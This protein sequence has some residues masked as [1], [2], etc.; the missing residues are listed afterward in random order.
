VGG[1]VY[2]SGVRVERIR[3]SY[4]LAYLPAESEPVAFGVHDV[5][6]DHY[7][8]PAAERPSTRRRSITSWRPPVAD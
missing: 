5:I 6:A 4:R 8:S 7:A 1:V 3:G 2:T